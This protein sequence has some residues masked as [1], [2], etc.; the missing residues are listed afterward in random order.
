MLIMLRAY[1]AQSHSVWIKFINQSEMSDVFRMRGDP[2]YLFV[3][4][5]S[6]IHSDRKT[7]QDRKTLDV[8]PRNIIERKLE[9]RS[10]NLPNSLH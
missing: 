4:D 3:H 10:K 1:L 7:H 5:H 8:F 9:D 2:G 6:R